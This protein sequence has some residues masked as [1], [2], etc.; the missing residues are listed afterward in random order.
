M[1]LKLFQ[2]HIIDYKIKNDQWKQIGNNCVN[3][4][5]KPVVIYKYTKYRE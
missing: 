2:K 3:F 5:K 4:G 1:S